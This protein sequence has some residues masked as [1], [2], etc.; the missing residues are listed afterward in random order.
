MKLSKLSSPLEDFTIGFD[1]DGK[2]CA[3]HLDWDTTR[4]TVDITE[5]K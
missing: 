3:M 1:G 5:K 4:A 2:T